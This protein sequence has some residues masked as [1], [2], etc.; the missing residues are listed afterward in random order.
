M[1]NYQEVGDENDFNELKVKVIIS[2]YAVIE[3]DIRNFI[4]TQPMDIDRISQVS[5]DYAVITTIFYYTKNEAKFIHEDI[6][7][8]EF[9]DK[10]LDYIETNYNLTFENILN[11]ISE[12][13]NETEKKS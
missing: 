7:L 4:N 2:D 12:K 13:I 1:K 11:I 5:V 9:A 6:P 8:R 3:E 10:T